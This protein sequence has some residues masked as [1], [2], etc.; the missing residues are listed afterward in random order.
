[1]NICREVFQRVR[2]AILKALSPK[3]HSLVW[4]K[5][6][7]PASEDQKFWCRVYGWILR[8]SE[9][10]WG[11]GM[12][13]FVGEKEDFV[14][15]AGLDWEPVEVDEGWADVLPGLGAGEDPGG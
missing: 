4:G 15:D 1:M 14:V 8:R 6:N 11:K 3:T 13:G 2:A 7:R 9:V 12:E 5:E 10:L